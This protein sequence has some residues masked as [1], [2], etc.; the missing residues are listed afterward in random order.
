MST[1]L[2][3]HAGALLLNLLVW[4]P[5]DPANRMPVY[6]A[7]SQRGCRGRKGGSLCSARESTLQL[8]SG[9]PGLWAR[10]HSPKEK[11]LRGEPLIDI[12]TRSLS[13]GSYALVFNRLFL[14]D[15]TED[16]R[17]ETARTSLST[18][19]AIRAGR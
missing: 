6:A 13:S 5:L 17:I 18:N 14:P 12:R 1:C 4:Q 8:S 16:S 10:K 9:G 15:M 19:P 11:G 2:E 3:E 7:P